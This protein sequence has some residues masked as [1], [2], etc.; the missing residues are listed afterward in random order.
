MRRLIAIALVSVLAVSCTSPDT[1]GQ[2]EEY[3]SA[4]A[5]SRG[6][7]GDATDGPEGMHVDFTG[8]YFFALATVL[9]PDQPIWLQADIT[10][11]SDLSTFD[12]VLQPLFVDSNADARTPVGDPI[13]A[14][15][16]PFNEDGTFTAVLGDV[17][18]AGGANPISGADIS[19]NL[20]IEGIVLANNA[21][22]GIP[23]GNVS[24]PVT[25]NDLTGS[26]FYAEVSAPS[27]FASIADPGTSCDDAP[28]Q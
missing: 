15:S 4:T 19:A 11:A 5:G 16:V 7:Q 17:L 20:N 23:T 10:V 24:S 1:E 27:D 12:L 26:T 14:D 13:I 18:V 9:D 2:Y 6:V 8:T 3:Q 22:C 25:L 21:F 28:A